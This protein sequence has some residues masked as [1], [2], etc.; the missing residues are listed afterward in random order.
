L[1]AVVI[2]ASLFHLNVENDIKRRRFDI[3]FSGVAEIPMSRKIRS[4][5]AS[6]TSV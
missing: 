6:K 1:D 2:L 5:K 4:E 3:V